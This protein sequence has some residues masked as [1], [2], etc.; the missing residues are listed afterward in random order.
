MGT[1]EE[2][3]A[4]ALI[5]AE[6]E[7]ETEANTSRRFITLQELTG[8]AEDLDKHGIDASICGAGA[9]FILSS[10]FLLIKLIPSFYFFFNI[11]SK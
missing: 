10:I 3:P 9:A 11:E 2:K 6:T 4:I 7:T 8:D 5:H 1:Q